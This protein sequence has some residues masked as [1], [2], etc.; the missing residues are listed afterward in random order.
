MAILFYS[1]FT[2]T[3]V[4]ACSLPFLIFFL[5]FVRHKCIMAEEVNAV[6]LKLPQFW[7]N[8]PAHWFLH[9]ESQFN[10]RG[11]TVE[12]TKYDYVISSLSQD[13]IATIYDIMA[14]ISSSQGTAE[15]IVNPYT[16]LK[17]YLI[18]RHTLSE[19][20]RI[21][22]LLSGLEM[23]DKKPSEFFRSLKT[24]AGTSD[25]VND[26][27]VL[28]LWMRKLPAMVQAT[29]KAVPKAEISDQLSMADNIYEIFR[30]QHRQQPS[31]SAMTNFEPSNDTISN[32]VAQNKRLEKEMSELKGMISRLSTDSGNNPG[33]SHSRTR[34]Q[35]RSRSQSRNG[36]T[37]QSNLCWYHE[38][39]GD[40]ASKCKK[41]C[42][43]KSSPN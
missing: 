8:L 41:P 36:R 5:S 9:I 3:Y 27:L 26:K 38:K 4:F 29:L 12:K 30:Q 17:K 13:A 22:T 21:E 2:Y 10:T 14:E 35:D 33:R 23:G 25:V 16:H 11:I 7:A 37:T 18:E 19:S 42:S 40:K 15:P 6:A 39:Y 32:L 1:I 20:S 43:F 34:N 24:L 31:I 28:N